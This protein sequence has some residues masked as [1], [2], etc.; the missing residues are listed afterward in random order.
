MA[1]P[2]IR[3]RVKELEAE[4][5]IAN[6][7]LTGLRAIESALPKTRDGVPIV[8]GMFVWH[9]GEFGSVR[10]EVSRDLHC[11]YTTENAYYS[12]EAAAL[13]SHRHNADNSEDKA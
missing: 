9:I 5:A 1:M 4:L 6:T 11:W 8:P 3:R 2:R 7:E 12:T 10:R 13:A